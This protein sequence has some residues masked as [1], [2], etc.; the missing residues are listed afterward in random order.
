MDRSQDL[1]N[2]D[3][4]LSLFEQ[5]PLRQPLTFVD[6]CVVARHQKLQWSSQPLAEPKK[7]NVLHQPSVHK[8]VLADDGGGGDDGGDEDAAAEAAVAVV[9]DY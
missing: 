1:E 8:A 5:L 2:D 6:L 4:F 3:G 7:P 9:A